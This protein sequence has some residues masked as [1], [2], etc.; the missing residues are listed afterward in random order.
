M[1][2]I[3]IQ[4][5]TYEF[6]EGTTLLEIAKQFQRA[7]EADIVLAKVNG[8]LQELH[9]KIQEDCELVFVS[10]KDK[11]GMSAYERSTTLLLLRAFYDVVGAKEIQKLVVDF[12]VRRG[13][14]VKPE[15]K[16]DLTEELLAKVEQKMRQMVKEKIPIEKRSVNTQEAVELFHLHKMYDKERLFHYRRVSK[17]NLYRIGGFEDYYYGYMVPDTGYLRYFSLQLYEN[18]FVLRLPNRA[19]PNRVAD[20]LPQPK[21]FLTLKEAG[22]WADCL[23]V[24]NVGML[25]DAVCEGRIP[26]LIQIQEALI[27]KKIGMIAEEIFRQP[28]KKLIMIAGPTSSGKTTFSHRLSIQLRAL[29]LRPHPIAADD[30]FIERAKCPRNPDGSYNFEDLQAMDLEFFHDTMSGLLNGKKMPMPTF[31]FKTGK[32]EFR[33]GMLELKPEDILVIEGIH[34]LNDAMSYGLDMEK[35]Y[36]IYISALTQLNIDEHNPIPTTDARLLRR[37]VRDARTRGTS[38][39]RTIEMWEDVRRGE[40][41][42][43]FPYQEQA[44]VMFNSA[45]VYELAVLKQ[46]AEPL[47]FGIAKEE[48]EYLEA[49]RLLKFLDYFLGVGSEN[50]PQNS[51]LR[52]FIGGSVFQI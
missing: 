48:P 33:G 16:V 35:K 51:I 36:K 20:F 39:K 46:Y 22:E 31:N 7:D 30:F 45:H 11:E 37:I 23:Q 24:S 17:V 2:A 10:T 1:A 28:S 26:E 12:S 15:M 14:F 52:E 49:K 40:E 41:K 3:Q 42:N 5:E 50:I 9:Q 21:L 32:R 19:E 27:E 4:G 13:L 8:K 44:D 34:C 29:G 6:A 18:G 47:L 25:N 43:I 38:A